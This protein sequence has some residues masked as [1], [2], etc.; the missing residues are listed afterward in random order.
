MGLLRPALSVRMHRT[1]GGGASRLGKGGVE[2]RSGRP[3]VFDLAVETV[4]KREI[5]LTAMAHHQ[6][7][8][9]SSLF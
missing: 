6:G 7:G 4:E 2:P 9:A 1:I 5:L 3:A 8:D